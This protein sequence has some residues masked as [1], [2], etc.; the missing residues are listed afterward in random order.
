MQPPSKALPTIQNKLDT[1]QCLKSTIFSQKILKCNVFTRFLKS[2]LPTK[3]SCSDLFSDS[4]RRY[5]TSRRGQTPE[6]LL[7]ANAGYTN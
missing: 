2:V 7:C 4:F 1:K 6:V 3:I 5:I